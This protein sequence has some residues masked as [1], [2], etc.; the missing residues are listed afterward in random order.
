MPYGSRLLRSTG[1]QE[2]T[3]A[4]ENTGFGA[5]GVEAVVVIGVYG[6]MLGILAAEGGERV[7]GEERPRFARHVSGTV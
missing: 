5:V 1:G 7:A 2:V 4:V 3:A 6:L